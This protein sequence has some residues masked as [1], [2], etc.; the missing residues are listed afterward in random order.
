MSSIRQQA[1]STPSS[2]RPVDAHGHRTAGETSTPSWCAAGGHGGG[3]RH[4]E[5]EVLAGRVRRRRRRRPR[6][7][8]GCAGCRGTAG[9]AAAPARAEERQCTWR[10]SSPGTYSRS[11]WKA[12]SLIETSSLGMPS[13]S[14]TDTGAE[15]LQ[16]HHPGPDVELDCGAPSAR[17]GAAAPSGS[18]RRA[19]DRADRHHAAAQVGAARGV[20]DG[21]AARGAS[22]AGPGVRCPPVGSRD[23][24]AG[25]REAT[26]AAGREPD[27]ARCH[28]PPPAAA[29]RQVPRSAR[30]RIAA[31]PPRPR[32]AARRPHHISRTDRPPAQGVQRVADPAEQQHRR[33][34]RG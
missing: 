21:P 19:S 32:R 13:W 6:R 25:H 10:R 23:E 12:R 11:A 30:D 34:R 33:D 15:R 2:P 24:R 8:R 20:L 28:R 4:G 18:V 22:A 7:W 1:S 14:R 3:D 9:R 17:P 5:L 31:R 29:Q 16:R 26:G 27:L